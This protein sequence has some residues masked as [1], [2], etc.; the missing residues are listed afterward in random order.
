MT[1][2][3]ELQNIESYGILKLNKFIKLGFLLVN[4]GKGNEMISDTQRY[5]KAPK[6]L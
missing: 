5:S 1:L 4:G 3:C 2:L 6:T